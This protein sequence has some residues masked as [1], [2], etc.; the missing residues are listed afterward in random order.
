MGT[1][2]QLDLSRAGK[3]K[4]RA[5]ANA[6]RKGIA[7]G[8]LA[9]GSKLPPV[10]DLA[11]RTSVTPGTVA[12][13]Y[14]L[15]IDEGL[16]E[17]GVGRGTFVADT[18]V[19]PQAPSEWPETVSFRSP[20]L[21]D[22]GQ[23]ELMRDALRTV[24]EGANTRSLMRYPNDADDR[25]LRDTMR[26]HLA[27]LPIGNF[28]ADDIVLAH[29]AQNAMLAVL[30]TVLDGPDPVVLVEQHAYP[31]FR[32]A[33]EL[34]RARVVAIE[35]DDEGARPDLLQEAIRRHRAQVF[36]TSAE[37]NNPTLRRTTPRRRR[38]I[39]SVARRYNL[40]V[41]DDDCY[42]LTPASAE[43]YRALLPDLGWYVSSLSKSLTPSLRVGWVIGPRRRSKELSR[44][45]S[46]ACFGLARPL[47]DITNAV[48][49][50]PRLPDILQ[51]TRATL[52][53]RVRLAVNHLGGHD[54][55]W[56]ED[57]PFLWISLP[58]GWRASR[59]VRAAQARGVLL[60]SSE[61]FVLRDNRAPH[62]VRM[63]INA[64]IA[65]GCFEKA[66]D[67]IRDLLD[68]PQDDISV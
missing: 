49:S 19:T 47:T 20:W 54:V 43:S 9:K 22:V 64:Q 5:L 45:V 62:S 36:L 63:A 30:Q 41:V 3:S 57:V 51:Q 40:H 7:D 67:T 61:D 68:N 60:K 17:A 33:A 65:T 53:E 39:A 58:G 2:W 66:V 48:L 24:A 34:C 15:L 16:L 37:V 27:G 23:T 12:R 28:E 14:S 4:Y 25:P 26:A 13:A 6:L 11:Y 21:P 55:T 44:T 18:Q 35:C 31:G 52:A 1:M 38:E 29:G 56:H 32:R 10:R 8:V 59:F 50:D 46:F 42:K